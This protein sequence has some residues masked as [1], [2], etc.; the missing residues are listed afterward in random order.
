MKTEPN[1]ADSQSKGALA[2]HVVHR[3]QTKAP[4]QAAALIY[5]GVYPFKQKKGE[6]S[7]QVMHLD[8]SG[9]MIIPDE[10]NCDYYTLYYHVNPDADVMVYTERYSNYN[11]TSDPTPYTYTSRYTNTVTET[12]QGQVGQDFPEILSW[13]FQFTYESSVTCEMDVSV[14]ATAEPGQWLTGYYGAWSERRDNCYGTHTTCDG[15]TVTVA[16][17][18]SILT[19]TGATGWLFDNSP[20]S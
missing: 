11:A 19:P 7:V 15:N 1:V 13:Q 8:R 17:G 6:S 2:Q 12:Y 16:S 10:D 18:F 4:V 14:T 5:Q 20:P 9:K 3:P